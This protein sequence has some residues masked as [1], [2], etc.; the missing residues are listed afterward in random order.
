MSALDQ[1][2]QSKI[3]SRVQRYSGLAYEFI[4]YDLILDGWLEMP[5]SPA[6]TEISQLKSIDPLLRTLLAECEE[7]AIQNA[8]VAILPLVEKVRVYLDAYR[9]AIL[10]RFELCGILWTPDQGD[11]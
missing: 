7:A 3:R 11:Q 5:P 6:I 2:W 10:S 4:S 1:E 8:N 9:A